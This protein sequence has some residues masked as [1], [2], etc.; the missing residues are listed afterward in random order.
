MPP[1]VFSAPSYNLTAPWRTGYSAAPSAPVGQPRLHVGGGGDAF[2]RRELIEDALHQLG[3]PAI[4]HLGQ[5]HLDGLLFRPSADLA[6][7]FVAL[8]PL[9]VRNRFAGSLGRARPPGGVL[10]CQ[11]AGLCVRSRRDGHHLHRRTATDAPS[12]AAARDVLAERQRQIGVKEMSTQG[13]D[14]YHR[15]QLALAA[16]FYA[17]ASAAAPQ[18]IRRG[19]MPARLALEHAVV[20]ATRCTPEPGADWRVDSG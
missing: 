12:T 11:S 19:H 20:E 7:E 1:A 5:K 17:Q 10:S 2:E 14:R 9:D 15:G 16:C 3:L 13:D 8:P 18:H 4:G 6:Q